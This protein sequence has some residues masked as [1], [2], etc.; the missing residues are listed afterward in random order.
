MKRF[1]KLTAFTLVATMALSMAACGKKDEKDTTEIAS[2]TD[3]VEAESTEATT[4]FVDDGVWDT[5]AVPVVEDDRFTTVEG[6]DVLGLNFDDGELGGFTTYVNGGKFD[7]YVENGEMV[8]DIAGTGKVE[9]GVQI[10]FDGFTMAKGC[11]YT[12][13][14]DVYSTIE[15]PAEWRVQVNGGDYH[16]YASDITNITTEKQT[17]TME[18]T[19]EENSDPA[20]RFVVNMG[21]YEGQ[22][23][24]PAHKVYF[25]NI[26]LFVTDSSNAEKIVGAPTPIQVKVNQIGYEPDDVKTVIVTSGDDTKFKIVNVDTNEEV[27]VGPYTSDLMFDPNAG[28]TLY[29]GDFTALNTPGRYKV[30]SC[31]SGASYEFSIGE[32][33][34]DDVYKDVVLML[35]NQRCGCALDENISGVFAHEACHTTE[36]TIYGD[37]SGTSYDVSGGWHDAGDYGR[38][39]VPGAKTV[40]D[41]FLAYEDFGQTSDDMGIPESGNGTPDLLDEA[42]YELDWMFKMQDATSG[43]VYHKVTALVFPET[44]LAV[45]ETDPLVLAPISY[46]ATADFAAVMA[47]A[48][49][50]YRD[51][52]AAYADKCLE[53]AKNAYAYIEANPEM[54]GYTNPEEIVTGEYPDA[55]LEDELLWASVEMYIATGDSKYLDTVKSSLEAN[56]NTGFGWASIGTYALYDLAKAEGIDADVQAQAKEKIISM[57]DTLLEACKKDGFFMGLK[58]YAWGSNKDVADNGMLLLVANNLQANDEYM[59]YA[60]KHRDYIFGV[61]A[62]GYCYV[63]GYGTLSPIATHHRPSQTLDTTM[64]GML[65]GGPDGNLEDPYAKAVL[66]GYP[67]ALCYVDNE[68]SFS[69][70]EI[71][72]YWNSPLIYL[73]TGL[74]Y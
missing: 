36:A 38:Y 19:M 73:M 51:I 42:R 50:V 11:V 30:I 28:S 22:P 39:V 2:S 23:E 55:F 9:H 1:K 58:T 34:Y 59:E 31:P 35:Y 18:F 53:A 5:T 56:Y 7:L 47:K 32:G 64:P 15:R 37:T 4:E 66:Y 45:D 48:S 70:N 10:Y 25:D 61:N 13:S 68:Q 65:V 24:L 71:T 8:A 41:L 27:F 12:V 49:V 17:V 62:T 20:P 6:A 52:D 57:A 33:L 43:G 69:C 44:V 40:Q 72:I 29:Q 3:A 74:L 16:A 21:H 46:A 26:S 63:T 67:K 54:V 60:K 14:F